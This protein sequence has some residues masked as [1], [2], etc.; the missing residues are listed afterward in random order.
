MMENQPTLMEQATAAWRQKD[1]AS[2]RLLVKQLIKQDSR[3]IDAWLLG[4]LVVETREDAIKCYER[5]LAIDSAHAYAQKKLAQLQG[6][7]PAIPVSSQPEQAVDHEAPSASQLIPKLSQGNW[8]MVLA[9][10]MALV[11]CLVVAGVAIWSGVNSKPTG[12]TPTTEELFN[13]LYLNARAA[14]SEN[15]VAYMATIHPDS[16]LYQQTETG[17]KKAFADYD[18]EFYFSNLELRSLKPDEARIHFTLSTR[19]RAG[20]AFRNN[21]VIGTMILK[22]DNGEK[23]K[24]FNQELEEIKYEDA[25]E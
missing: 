14:N 13:V 17:M 18:L 20:P 12:P 21:I 4:A 16:P 24:I 9:G 6:G 10:A 19:K 23:W 1:Y 11:F 7:Q 5:V 2:A 25:G 15:T 3:N 8:I 22:P